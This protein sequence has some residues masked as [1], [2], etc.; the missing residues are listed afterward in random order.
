MVAKSLIPAVGYVRMS[1]SQ[2]DASPG[3]QR[4]EITKLAEKTGYRLIRWYEDPGIS[5]D[6]TR[7]RKHFLRMLRDIQEKG[8]FAAILC[9]DQDRFGRFDTIEAGSIIFPLRQAGIWLQTVTQGRIDWNTFQG[10]LIYTVQQ[11][12]KHQ[13][14]IDLSRNVLRGKVASTETVGV[15]VIRLA[16]MT[17]SFA[18]NTASPRAGS[19]T[20]RSF[21]G[22]RAG[23]SALYSP[24]IRTDGRGTLDLADVRRHGLGRHDDSQRLEPTRNLDA[25]RQEMEYRDESKES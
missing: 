18:M 6:D 22:R 14:L 8:D 20:P 12:G 15:R 9:W 19:S 5:G 3:Q 25:Q 17:A 24:R 1:S 21:A 2:Q 23:P 13:Y 4:K 7:K 16:V 11:E 10:R